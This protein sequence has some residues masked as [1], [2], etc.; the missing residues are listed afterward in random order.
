M[1][2]IVQ[3]GPSINRMLYIAKLPTKETSKQRVVGKSFFKKIQFNFN[4]KF[5]RIE[6][7]RFDAGEGMLENNIIC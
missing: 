5:Q 2:T 7:E 6:P 1:Q 4:M 3:R